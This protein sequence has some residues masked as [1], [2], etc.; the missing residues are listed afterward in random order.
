MRVAI[1][2]GSAPTPAESD[3][4][5][6]PHVVAQLRAEFEA[7][8]EALVRHDVARLDGYFWY[9]PH[10]VRY[11]VAE[12]LYGGYMIRS[13]RMACAP[14]SPERRIDRVVVTTF[15]DQF[16]TVAAEFS[17]PDSDANGRQLQTWVKFPE[18]WRVVSAHVSVI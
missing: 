12:N 3:S 4:V 7:Y 15:G 2:G 10:T 9:H 1:E 5:N 14:V 11:G 16:G 8:E 13:Y 6:L 18:G 17:A